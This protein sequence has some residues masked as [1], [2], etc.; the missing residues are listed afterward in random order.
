MRD[1]RNR[2]RQDTQKNSRR[3]RSSAIGLVVDIESFHIVALKGHVSFLKMSRR[4][5]KKT[6]RAKRRPNVSIGRLRILDL[7]DRQ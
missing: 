1:A 7:V 2:P 6:Q 3:M 5:Y 4:S